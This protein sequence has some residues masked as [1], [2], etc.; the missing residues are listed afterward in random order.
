[1]K[2]NRNDVFAKYPNHCSY[3]GKEISI[4]EMQ[5]DHKYPLSRPI[6]P[7]MDIKD[8]ND[9][10]NL[11]PS[12]WRCNHYKRGMTL[13]E[14]RNIMKTLIERCN[15]VYIIKVALDYGILKEQTWD[16][17]FYFERISS[18]TNI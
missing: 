11:Y 9:I 12:C 5:I 18:E 16:G 4:K 7:Y 2:V 3:C 6:Q 10:K 13:E 15:K 17:K 1:M 14:F 8:H